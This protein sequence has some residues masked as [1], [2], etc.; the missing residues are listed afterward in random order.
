[1]CFFL[2][3]AFYCFLFCCIEIVENHEFCSFLILF[4]IGFYTNITT[5]YTRKSYDL[6][7]PILNAHGTIR[8]GRRSW[9][10]IV[11]LRERREQNKRFKKRRSTRPDHGLGVVPGEWGTIVLLRERT[12]GLKKVGTRP[13]LGTMYLIIFSCTKL[14]ICYN[15][16]LVD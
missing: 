12:N 1:M 15:N 13:V 16:I 14:L 11:L 3:F 9:W 2:L 5:V 10:T 8:A 4:A 6:Y 7:P